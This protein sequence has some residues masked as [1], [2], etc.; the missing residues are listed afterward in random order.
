VAAATPAPA[1]VE[2]PPVASTPA[3]SAEQ[4]QLQTDTA[5]LLQLVQEL[6]LEI[7]KA[8]SN[9]LSLVAVRKAE[10]IQRLTKALKDKM[11]ER[12][13]GFVSK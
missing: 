2:P 11:S 6:K 5:R 4:R 8:G 7:E 9:T 3:A 12:A 1:P 13:Q 10:E